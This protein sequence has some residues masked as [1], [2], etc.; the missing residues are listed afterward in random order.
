MAHNKAQLTELLTNYGAID[1][2][3]FDGEAEGLWSVFE[4]P[5]DILCRDVSLDR[6]AFDLGGMA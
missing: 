3:F 5:A 4:E 1:M 6:V 2:M